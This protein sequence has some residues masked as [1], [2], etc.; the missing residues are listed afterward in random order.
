[1]SA[2]LN[3][4][5][6]LQRAA[7]AFFKYDVA[8]KRDG[9]GLHL[10]L[11]DRPEPE[12]KR[13]KRAS[14][15]HEDAVARKLEQELVLIHRHLG[16]L[17]A[18]VPQ[19]RTTLRQLVFVE[20]AIQ[21]KGM[22]ALHKLPLGVLQRAL[23]QLE[24][25]VTNWSPEGLANLRS[26]MAVAILDREHMDPCIE[27]DAYNTAAVLDTMPMAISQPDVNVVSDEDALAAAYA[28]LGNMMHTEA[29]QFQG[30]LGSP[31]A[32]AVA[33]PLPRLGESASEIKLRELQ[34]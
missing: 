27:A 34:T 23:E 17:L 18:E 24:G 25:L 20:E 12:Q 6:S 5:D 26:K 4:F 31:S 16:D 9:T 28:A 1:M 30:E 29:I 7:A 11:E 8:L 22:R 3:L 21:K 2:L 14:G 13:K 32:K 19:S 10:A 33:P 15:S